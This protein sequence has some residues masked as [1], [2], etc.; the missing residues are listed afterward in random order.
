MGIP[1]LTKTLN[2][3]GRA[4]HR[5]MVTGRLG[6][7]PG[8]IIE[9]FFGGKDCFFVQVGSNDG[10][11]GDPLHSAI[12]ANPKWRGIF[13]E[14]LEDVFQRLVVNYSNEGRFAFEKIAISDTNGEEWFYYASRETVRDLDLPDAAQGFGS[15]NREHVL[16]HFK[17]AKGFAPALFTK[18]PEAYISRKLIPCETLMSVLNRHRVSGIDVFHVD[19]ESHD[20]EIIRQLDFERFRPKLILYEDANL[21]R[22]AK[23]ARSFLRDKGYL[24]AKCGLLDTIAVR[25]D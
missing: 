5:Y 1:V 22:E 24:L 13:I 16:N 25:R 14:P 18:D 10:L 9:R 17:L 21:G 15:L 12:K 6:A 23:D 8:P 11:R 20:Y 2:R 3:V 4:A 19:A 7:A